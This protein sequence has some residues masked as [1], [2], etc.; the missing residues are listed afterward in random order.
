MYAEFKW[1]LCGDLKVVPLLHGM[2]LGY[3]K[4][5]YFLCDW[6]IRDK[7]YHYVNQLWHK[8][9]SLTRVDKNDL[10]PTLVLPEKIYLPTLHIKMGLKANFVKCMD[11]IS[12]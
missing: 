1:K 6:D 4:Y 5:C 7:K 3:T 8:R 12:C 2:Q 10:N 11:K 9:T